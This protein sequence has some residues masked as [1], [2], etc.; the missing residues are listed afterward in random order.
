MICTGLV[1]K[2]DMGKRPIWIKG[3]QPKGQQPNGRHNQKAET[4]KR[5][6]VVWPKVHQVSYDFWYKLKAE[7]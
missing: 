7:T 6:T 5:L 3:R 1:Q 4:D 2:A